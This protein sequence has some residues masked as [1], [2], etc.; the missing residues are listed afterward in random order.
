MLGADMRYEDK[1]AIAKPRRG[2]CLWEE[3]LCK[4]LERKIIINYWSDS[5]RLVEM[6]CLQGTHQVD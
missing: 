2:L 3:M 6:K 1:Q 5:S 4:F